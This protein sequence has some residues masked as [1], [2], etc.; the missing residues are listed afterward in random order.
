M[1]TYD[2]LTKPLEK[3]HLLIVIQKALERDSLKRQVAAL[4]SDVQNRYATIVG[5]QSKD[6]GHH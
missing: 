2:F 4:K 6:Q 1:E 3:D 5:R